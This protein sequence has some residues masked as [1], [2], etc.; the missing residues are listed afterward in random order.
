MLKRVEK[1]PIFRQIVAIPQQRRQATER[2][3]R[4]EPAFWTPSPRITP[5]H[6]SLRQRRGKSEFWAANGPARKA[7]GQ[8]GGAV[9]DRGKFWRWPPRAWGAKGGNAISEDQYR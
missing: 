3:H 9:P 1:W 6:T 2:G 5:A 4:E 7:T 8:D